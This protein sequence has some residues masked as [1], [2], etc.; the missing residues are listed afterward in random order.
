MTNTNGFCV[1]E[2]RGHRVPSD[3]I[4]AS[5]KEVFCLMSS[6]SRFHIFTAV[7]EV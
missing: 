5:Y 6:L 1:V 7:N 4:G 3:G 2:A